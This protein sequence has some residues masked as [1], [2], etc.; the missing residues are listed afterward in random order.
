MKI[1]KRS[2]LKLVDKKFQP[3]VVEA[4]KN[5]EDV[6][7]GVTLISSRKPTQKE[8]DWAKKNLIDR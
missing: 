7:W 3:M 5:G 6:P 2:Q 1:L 4:W 8:I